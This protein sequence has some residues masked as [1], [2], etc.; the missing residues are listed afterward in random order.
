MNDFSRLGLGTVQF[1]LDYG[2]SNVSGKTTLPEV[3]AILKMAHE[4]GISLLDT[5]SD[6]GDSE[7]ILGHFFDYTRSASIVTKT[8]SLGEVNRIGSEEVEKLNAGFSASL[9]KLRR[10]SIYALLAHRPDYL[11]AHGG[12]RV[13][14]WMIE[15]K[16]A[17]LVSRIGVSVY[18][19]KDIEAM[20]SRYQID[21]IQLPIHIMDQRLL[22]NG[23]LHDLKSHGIEI[24][25]RSV[26]LQGLLLMPLEQVPAWCSPLHLPLRSY[27]Q[28]LKEQSL[29]PLEAALA[30]AKNLPELDYIL[31]GAQSVAQFLEIVDAWLYTPENLKFPEYANI[32]SACLDPRKWPQSHKTWAIKSEE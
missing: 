21:I 8:I 7:L 2:I 27:H 3:E 31:V 18:E 32:E 1:G 14:Q 16:E 26:F 10:P 4:K 24:H 19:Q 29:S 12:E 22:K 23:M 28:W 6:Y 30:F 13:Y 11:L 15:L 9:L 25:A 20:L 5:A 17:G